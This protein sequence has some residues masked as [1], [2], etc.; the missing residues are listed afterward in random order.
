MMSVGTK[1]KE[2]GC[3]RGDQ[4]NLFTI[5]DVAECF[6]VATRTVRRWIKSGHLVAYRFG[7]VV[8]IAESDLRT[9]MAA[10]RDDEL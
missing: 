4:L 9:F 7:G 8:R 2:G 10:Y 1:N 6:H 5:S 3:R